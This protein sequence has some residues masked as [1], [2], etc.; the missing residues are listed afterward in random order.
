MPSLATGSSLFTRET[1]MSTEQFIKSKKYS[2]N[3]YKNLYDNHYDN[4]FSP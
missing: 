2:E 1:E 4:H 3:V